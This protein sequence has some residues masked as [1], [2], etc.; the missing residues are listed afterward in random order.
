MPVS[1]ATQPDIQYHP[2]PVKYKALTARRLDQNPELLKMSLL[3]GFPTKVEGPIVWEGKD[4]VNEDQWVYKLNEEEIQEIEDAVAH[5]ESRMLRFRPGFFVKFL[6]RPRKAPGLYQ[7]GNIPTSESESETSQIGWGTLH[8]S[9]FLRLKDHSYWEV[10]S[11]PTRYN[12]CRFVLVFVWLIINLRVIR[13]FVTC[14]FCSREAGC[15]W[16]CARTYQGFDRQSCMW[17][18]WYR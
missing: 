18:G 11:Y 16:C 3:S 14:G 6:D 12:L 8:W 7:S 13:C 15:H 2:D 1:V 17:A 10:W 5:F 9:R 4:W